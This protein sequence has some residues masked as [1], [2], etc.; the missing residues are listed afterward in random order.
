LCA[1]AKD[2]RFLKIRRNGAVRKHSHDEPS[3]TKS[4]YK[5]TD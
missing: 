4:V 5:R 2:L 1:L 3:R